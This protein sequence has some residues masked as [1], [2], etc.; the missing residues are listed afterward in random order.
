MADR[1]NSLRDEVEYPRA[2][3][4]ECGD[5]T[6]DLDGFGFVACTVCGYCTHPS[7]TDGVCGICGDK[8]ETPQA[9]EG[10]QFTR[11]IY[12]MAAKAMRRNAEAGAI[13]TSVQSLLDLADLLDEAAKHASSEVKR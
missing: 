13:T 12:E 6:E 2:L 10:W 9:R 1:D 8:A 11:E 7:R 3:C 5:D 4:P